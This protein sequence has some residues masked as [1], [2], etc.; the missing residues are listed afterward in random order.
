MRIYLWFLP[1]LFVTAPVFAEGIATDGSMGVAQTLT[2]SS[3]S[4]PQELGKTVGNNL[5]HSFS[6]FNINNGQTVTF[7]G[8]DSLQNVISRVTGN[9][10]SV[11]DGTLKSDIKNADFYFINPHGITFNANAQVDVPAAFH[12]STANKMDFGKNGGVFYADMSKDS[13]LS[14]EPPSAFGFLGTTYNQ[15]T[16][17]GAQLNFKSH[18]S[19]DLVAT[20]Y[21]NILNNAFIKAPGGEV[22]MATRG[23][24]AG[25]LSLER[26][27]G[28]LP[29]LP[30][31][32]G[33]LYIDDSQV[34]VSDK[35][36]GR[37]V[38]STGYVGMF[39]SQLMA[40]S[41]EININ[42]D[43]DLIN[44][45][46][47]KN[48]SVGKNRNISIDAENINIEGSHNPTGILSTTT[49]SATQ[50][51]GADIVVNAKKIDIKEGFIKS[52]SLGIGSAGRVEVNADDIHLE[53]TGSIQSQSTGLGY[54]GDVAV[55]TDNL[56]I[57][58]SQG[59][60]AGVFSTATSPEK[61]GT[62]TLNANKTE[63]INSTR[64]ISKGIAT[65]GFIPTDSL[66]QVLS[67]SDNQADV[68]IP[69]T[70]GK[71]IDHTLFHSFSDFNIK[72]FQ[73]VT[74]TGNDALKS[75]IAR[76]TGGNPSYLL[77]TLKSEAKNADIYFINP[78]GIT[79]GKY[80]HLD[81]PN[82][83]YVST[84]D[85]VTLGEKGIFYADLHKDSILSGEAPSSF[86]FL[87]TSAINNGLVDIDHAHLYLRDGKAFDVVAGGVNI[88]GNRNDWLRSNI[89]STAG[90][91]RLVALSGQSSV[92][93]LKDADAILPIPTLENSQ[94]GFINLDGVYI[95]ST[96]KGNE[97]L[98][99]WGG[100]IQLKNVQ[101]GEY[102]LTNSSTKGVDI[103][104]KNLSM[105]DSDI[106][107][108]GDINLY[109]DDLIKVNDNLP[110]YNNQ[111]NSYSKIMITSKNLDLFQT[112]IV[113]NS[114]DIT[115]NVSDTIKMNLGSF[116]SNAIEDANAGEITV[117]TQR[118][119]MASS[120]I[121]SSANNKDYNGDNVR[122]FNGNAGKVYINA[123]DMVK[124][125]D[126]SR[127]KSITSSNGNAGAITINTKDLDIIYGD[128][129][130][131]SH[132]DNNVYKFS[133]VPNGNAGKIN[134]DATGSILI[135]LGAVKAN[136]DS[137][138]DAGKIEIKTKNLE[139]LRDNSNIACEADNVTAVDNVTAAVDKNQIFLMSNANAGD[140]DI[141]AAGMIKLN[142]SMFTKISADTNTNGN[143]GSIK[144]NAKDVE[145]I[146][147]EISSSAKSYSYFSKY[148]KN[149]NIINIT[150][151]NAGTVDIS[152][153]ETIKLKGKDVWGAN[154]SSNAST[155]GNAG[156]ITLN[157]KNIEITSSKV[158][159]AATNTD[160]DT[161]KEEYKVPYIVNANA[162]NIAIHALETIKLDGFLEKNGDFY[163]S[164]ISSDTS[165]NGNGGLIYISANNIDLIGSSISSSADSTVLN[166]AKAGTIVIEAEETLKLDAEGDFYWG[167]SY[168]STS[169]NN[170]AGE[171][172]LKAKN[173]NLSGSAIYSNIYNIN[174]NFSGDIVNSG[175]NAMAG[176]ITINV[177]DTLK[178]AGKY[179]K[180]RDDNYPS[181]ITS[182]TN[183]NAKAGTLDIKA[184]KLELFDSIISSSVR[185]DYY[186]VEYSNGNGSI[187]NRTAFGNAGNV[188]IDA[189]NIMLTG[190][191]ASINSSTYALGGAGDL[192]IKAHEVNILNFSSISSGSINN[193]GDNENFR[194]SGINSSGITGNIKI[195]TQDLNL[196]SGGTITI[197]NEAV[198]KNNPQ[199]IPVGTINVNAK[200]INI[201]NAL[202]TSES[203][204]NVNAGSIYINYDD[205]F[206][207]NNKAFI[208]ATS[209]DGNG[210]YVSI[211]S[212]SGVLSLQNS[213]I[214]T[215]ATGLTSNGGNIDIN[216]DIMIM[217]TGS[218][219]ASTVGGQGGNITLNLQSLVPSS[220]NL[221]EVGSQQ[222]NWN[223]YSGLNVL[224]ASG[225]IKS[226]VPQLNLSGVLVN[227][228]NTT[229]DNNLISQDYCALGQ[230]SSL[231]KKGRGALPMRP[232]NLQSF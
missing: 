85:V 72:A 156:F 90:E 107:T 6:D 32:S 103:N 176:T 138:G 61:V 153:T 197:K 220:N 152:V 135:G 188:N 104:A 87:G 119:E 92:D 34:D 131:S 226:N 228:T 179:Y 172:I 162:G 121:S 29:L 177:D 126:G 110:I 141:N 167:K 204:G 116:E 214:A 147:G 67:A 70:L 231:S 2:G 205:L 168:I 48:E 28:F 66:S 145:L 118:L 57:D 224:G 202:I 18:Q 170:N 165:T 124:L 183:T 10:P 222:F 46:I 64:Q 60:N 14:S 218:L 55:T 191:M 96:A 143:A 16:I 219:L 100:D 42:G 149:G 180:D 199:S 155:N 132:T 89:E 39:N 225:A 196:K 182:E 15:I 144:I 59:G 221:I 215:T 27:D 133:D 94:G 83:F 164:R 115:V 150:N 84:A 161:D 194:E 102:F 195:D 3:I 78:N 56:V 80:A 189:D 185:N 49:S 19:V 75:I 122:F 112:A 23:Y 13:Q 192:R 76:V 40:T 184:K 216:S 81:L 109:V 31:T 20:G 211:N 136:T 117:N 106:W 232:H 125:E 77:G 11:I 137:F 128:I 160:T 193:N 159:S 129:D 198:V 200:N 9:N 154:I 186:F 63:I 7:S 53:G 157:A 52:S 1:S 62:V 174:H 223:P 91:I 47:I 54:A 134:I 123:T 175:T 50:E 51:Q 229:V 113:S 171:I 210:G 69:E 212:P 25:S 98:A 230:G 181:L 140:I 93:L 101:I 30:K 163:G 82:D 130:S 5:F 97:H 45:G 35:E 158:S 71:T 24:D 108:H 73:T 44:G 68:Y 227:I 26:K 43:V 38:V 41:G 22:R 37:I 21:F 12:V 139:L 206:K 8:S 187:A 36:G 148:D 166:D 33:I 142:G 178:M 209:V 86:G 88:K 114:N 173:L 95:N 120:L 201:N 58:N 190:K 213:H 79:F 217:N 74:F 99:V 146:G 151:G 207:L 17:Q 208:N 65:D 105:F 111:I 169:G 127:I 203:T 4:I